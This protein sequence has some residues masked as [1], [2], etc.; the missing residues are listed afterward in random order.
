IP[1][2]EYGGGPMIVWDWGTW[3]PMGDLVEGLKKGDFKFR[4]WG[5]KLKGGWVLVR[6]K[7]KPGD[8]GK[9]NWLV[10]KE[11]DNGGDTA[12]DVLAA[13]PESVKSGMT[14]EELAASKKP[15]KPAKAKPATKAAKLDPGKLKGAVPAPMPKTYRPQLATQADNPPRGDAEWLHE[16]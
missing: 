13:R 3:A 4:L 12:T 1:E 10:V 15:A 5:E 7:P 11:K 9:N 2:G 8:K 16:I 14:I 6:M